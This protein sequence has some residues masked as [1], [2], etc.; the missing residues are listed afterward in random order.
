LIADENVEIGLARRAAPA[1]I[2][3]AAEVMVLGRDGY[4]TA[5]KGSNGF[6]CIVERSSAKPTDD[7]EFWNS[8]IRAP[9]LF[10]SGSLKD[11][12]AHLSEENRT[13]A[14]GRI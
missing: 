8:K 7:P 12:S 6:V 2:S 9:K 1:S 5:V 13:C 11:V 4:A 14:G 10:Q 3:D